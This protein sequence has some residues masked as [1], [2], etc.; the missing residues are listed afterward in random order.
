MTNFV[1]CC[2]SSAFH[3]WPELRIAA[4]IEASMMTSLGTW[5]LVIPRL[6]AT[7]ARARPPAC[8]RRAAGGARRRRRPAGVRRRDGVRDRAAD[9]LRQL[10]HV[11]QH[12][13]EPLVRVGAH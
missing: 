2:W 8:G 11:G 12:P 7:C 13:A 9:V 5:R 3:I 1:S 10:L 6:E 4:G